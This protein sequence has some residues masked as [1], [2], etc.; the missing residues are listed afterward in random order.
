MYCSS[1]S[2]ISPDKKNIIWKKANDGLNIEVSFTRFRSNHIL[3]QANTSM[4]RPTSVISPAKTVPDGRGVEIRD[5]VVI[6]FGL[7]KKARRAQEDST[8][9]GSMGEAV[10]TAA[11]AQ[12]VHGICRREQILRTTAPQYYSS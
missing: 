10:R 11:F 1:L 3:N 5:L 6:T 8:F 2:F 9:R 7:M 12:Q 4:T